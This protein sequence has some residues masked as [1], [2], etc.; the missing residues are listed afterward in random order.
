MLD[1]LTEC[2]ACGETIEIPA[3]KFEATMPLYDEDEIIANVTCEK[4][5]LGM[6]TAQIIFGEFDEETD[7]ATID[8]IEVHVHLIEDN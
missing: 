5:K 6:A 3:N 8:H 7:T 1:I 2:P 4:C